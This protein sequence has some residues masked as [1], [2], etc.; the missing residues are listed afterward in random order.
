MRTLVASGYLGVCLATGLLWQI[1]VQ[2]KLLAWLPDFPTYDLLAML[3]AV[4]AVGATPLGVRGMDRRS[5]RKVAWGLGSLFMLFA[6]LHAGLAAKSASL[7]VQ[8][9]RDTVL[10]PT[11]LLGAAACLLMKPPGAR[12]FSVAAI[13]WSLGAA[14]VSLFATW[15]A[16]SLGE[17]TPL[18]TYRFLLYEAGVSAA[19]LTLAW[20]HE[21]WLARQNNTRSLG[22][23]A[24]LALV[25]P[26]IA[27]ALLK[28]GPQFLE[29]RLPLL[30]FSVFGVRLVGCFVFSQR[31]YLEAIPD[32]RAMLSQEKTLGE[33]RASPS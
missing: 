6:L 18:A 5:E 4:T 27:V 21:H 15:Y 32:E 30:L 8:A 11:V 7:A 25:T 24:L 29:I 14:C 2:I 13:A 26:L 31:Y 3:A 33:D 12:V 16:P 1:V 9:W 17:A 10:W 22:A 23:L 19:L 28:L 20:G